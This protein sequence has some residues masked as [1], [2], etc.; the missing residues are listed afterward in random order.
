LLVLFELPAA[1]PKIGQG[2]D[3]KSHG[4]QGNQ[5]TYSTQD[6]RKGVGKVGGEDDHEV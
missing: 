1:N 4:G 3:E 6:K 2:P 5:I